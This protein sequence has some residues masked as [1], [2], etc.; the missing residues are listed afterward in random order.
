MRVHVFFSSN[1][2]N[3]HEIVEGV[4]RTATGGLKKED[5]EGNVRILAMCGIECALVLAEKIT[6]ETEIRGTVRT[7]DLIELDN[8]IDH[9]VHRSGN[10]SATGWRSGLGEGEKSG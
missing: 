5:P 10:R 3:N 8:V 9:G 7:V 1:L 4:F 2:N 6:T